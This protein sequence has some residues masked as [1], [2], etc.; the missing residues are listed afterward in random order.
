MAEV[1]EYSLE[2]GPRLYWVDPDDYSGGQ[3]WLAM[4]LLLLLVIVAYVPAAEGEFIW[5]D[6]ANVTANDVLRSGNA[7]VWSWIHPVAGAAASGSGAYR[8]LADAFYWPQ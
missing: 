5:R 4:G 6:D 3:Q 7:L 1:L 2:P 8:P